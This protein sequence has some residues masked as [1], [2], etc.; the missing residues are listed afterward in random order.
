M[1]IATPCSKVCVID[2]ASGL[3]AGCGRTLDEIARWTALTDGERA[4]IMAALP[5][6]MAHR[7]ASAAAEST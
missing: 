3:C 1:P 2:P 5:D 7:G 6:R 4:R